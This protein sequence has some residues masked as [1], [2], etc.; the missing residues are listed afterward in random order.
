MG[1]FRI[2]GVNNYIAGALLIFG[3]LALYALGSSIYF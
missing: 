1:F 3:L 2:S